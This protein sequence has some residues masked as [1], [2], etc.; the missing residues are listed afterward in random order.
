MR[1]APR[2]GEVLGQVLGC[3]A[4]K[5][6]IYS[7]FDSLLASMVREM[8]HL[9]ILAC[10]CLATF[11]SQIGPELGLPVESTTGIG[12]TAPSSIEQSRVQVPLPP[13]QLFLARPRRFATRLPTRQVAIT[14]RRPSLY[15]C[16]I[17]K[18]VSNSAL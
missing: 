15:A 2:H 7:R 12:T 18:A 1:A 5:A 10:L 9:I 11:S 6:V 14:C 8:R 13:I 16:Y 4:G 3:Q 17:R